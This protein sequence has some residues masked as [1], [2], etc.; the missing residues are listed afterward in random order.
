[1]L[2]AREVGRLQAEL[3]RLS[4]SASASEERAWELGLGRSLAEV[5]CGLLEL[6]SNLRALSPS[7][8]P[9]S[10]PSLASHPLAAVVGGER[11]GGVMDP[12]AELAA[13]SEAIDRLREA[14]DEL[15]RGTPPPWMLKSYRKAVELARGCG[16]PQQR[17]AWQNRTLA[18][19]QPRPSS[20]SRP[21][22]FSL[23]L[24][25]PSGYARVPGVS[26]E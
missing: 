12:A 24:A 4:H 15:S 17:H 23:D 5:R 22:G 2:H 20:S 21:R 9:F 25:R 19:V 1:M 8:S 16:P 26:A 14:G 13:I 6:L 11:G 18:S 7:L 10:S 3:R